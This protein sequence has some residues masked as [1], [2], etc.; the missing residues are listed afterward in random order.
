[1]TKISVKSLFLLKKV[2]PLLWFGLL[3]VFVALAF[4]SGVLKEDP[5]AILIFPCGMAVVGYLMMRI[6]WDLVDE[7]YDCGDCLLVKN[8][9]Q[10]EMIPLSN[11]MNV[12]VVTMINPPR[13]TL[14][15]V[16][17]GKFG[18]EI[19]FSPTTSFTLNPFVKNQV[20]EDLIVRVDRARSQRTA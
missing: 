10:E 2:F 5:F 17:A 1:M 12:N 6:V 15:L 4:L 16:R 8:A 13:I 7:V 14:R 9:G 18:S 20:V 3:V 11:I 19:S